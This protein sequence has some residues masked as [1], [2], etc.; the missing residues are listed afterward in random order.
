MMVERYSASSEY[1][2]TRLYTS[3]S[4][5]G[6][7]RGE[8][9]IEMEDDQIRKQPECGERQNIAVNMMIIISIL[10]DIYY[11]MFIIIGGSGDFSPFHSVSM[12][13]HG[14]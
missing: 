5:R 13:V 6:R 8:V 4:E 1:L 9:L 7:G 10:V 14:E 3:P 11:Y 2:P 12:S